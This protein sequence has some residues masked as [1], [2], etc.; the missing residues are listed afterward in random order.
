[1]GFVCTYCVSNGSLA[2]TKAVLRAI[3]TRPWTKHHGI[4]FSFSSNCRKAW[5]LSSFDML[6]PSSSY[7]I[8]R[9]FFDTCNKDSPLEL[10]NKSGLRRFQGESGVVHNGLWPT[11]HTAAEMCF[12][13][14]SKVHSQSEGGVDFRGNGHAHGV[15]DHTPWLWLCIWAKRASNGAKA[16]TPHSVNE[17]TH[18][19]VRHEGGTDEPSGLDTIPDRRSVFTRSAAI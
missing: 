4:C 11:V 5:G 15:A 3:Q 8:I 10:S 1:M 12:P 17:Q 7:S 18:L 16:S 2:D 19:I 14:G 9:G 6:E 13:F